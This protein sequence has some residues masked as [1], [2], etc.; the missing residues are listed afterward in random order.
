[1]TKPLARDH[2]YRRRRFDAE[3]IELCVRW[4]ITY[5]LSYRDLAAMMAER[6]IIVSHTTILRWV[7][8]YV[9]EFEKR[10]SRF[11]RPVNTSW[12]VDETYINISGRWSYLYRAVD[13]HGK[14]VDFLLRPDRTIAAAQAFFR[15]ALTTTLPRWP[16][17]VTLDGNRQSHSALRLLRREDPKWKHV[18]VRSSQYLNNL[19]EQ[20]HRAIKRRCASMGGFKSFGTAA[21][22][23]AGI[24]L[25]HRIRKKQFSLGRGRYRNFGSLKQL[26][27]RALA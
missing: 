17:K 20:D 10:W 13:K 3:I 7:I 16:R 26:W 9:P 2:I 8:R 6:G 25:A 1:M 23:L 24:E 15:K 11:A 4:Y 18:Q 21:V 19:I 12:R 22:T 5:R 14:T 27:A